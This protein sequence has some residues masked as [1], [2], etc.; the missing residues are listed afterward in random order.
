MERHYAEKIAWAMVC[1]ANNHPN[2]KNSQLVFD[3]WTT[4]MDLRAKIAEK[5]LPLPIPDMEEAIQEELD[6]RPGRGFEVKV[7]LACPLRATCVHAVHDPAQCLD[8]Q[9]CETSLLAQIRGCN[10]A[11]L[12]FVA[13]HLHELHE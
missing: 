6:S 3:P 8:L 4:A 11:L 9:G 1:K 13:Y 12:Q 7:R 2:E 5:S 10:D